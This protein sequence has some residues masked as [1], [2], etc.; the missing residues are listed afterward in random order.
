MKK[1]TFFLFLTILVSFSAT[2]IGMF[3]FTNRNSTV[4]AWSDG[5]NNY[6]STE[7]AAAIFQGDTKE[8]LPDQVTICISTYVDIEDCDQELPQPKVT[9]CNL[10][11]VL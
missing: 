6:T 2:K 3:D 9:Q 8:P 7:L 10:R 5:L 1:M 11:V 4:C